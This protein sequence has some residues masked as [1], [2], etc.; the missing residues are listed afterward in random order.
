M[1]LSTSFGKCF[2]VTLK[3]ISDTKDF[4]FEMSYRFIIVIINEKKYRGV[5]LWHRKLKLQFILITG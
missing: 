3:A 1:N 5:L 4:I 2:V